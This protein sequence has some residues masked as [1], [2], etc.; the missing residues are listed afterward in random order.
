[1]RP[2]ETPRDLNRPRETPRGL[3]RLQAQNRIPMRRK[4]CATRTCNSRS[5][6]RCASNCSIKRPARSRDNATTSKDCCARTARCNRACCSSRRPPSQ[7]RQDLP[8]PAADRVHEPAP[9]HYS[10]D[11]V[12]NPAAASGPRYNARHGAHRRP[13]QNGRPQHPS[14]QRRCR[15]DAS[16]SRWCR[17]SFSTSNAVSPGAKLAYALA[18]ALRLAERLLL[19]RARSSSPRTW[20]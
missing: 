9:V 8:P 16:A 20:A 10:Q 3:M 7:D 12:D 13:T 2:R 14:P 17:I 5:T 18:P 4:S 15:I 11:N 1:M 19:S 6:L